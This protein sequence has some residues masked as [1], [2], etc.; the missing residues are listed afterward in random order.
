MDVLLTSVQSFNNAAL[1]EHKEWCY[2]QRAQQQQALQVIISG[3][4]EQV[5]GTLTG[6]ETITL[7]PILDDREKV[8]A[9][10]SLLQERT[11][12]RVQLEQDLSILKTHEASDNDQDK[13]HEILETKSIRL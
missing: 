6:I 11:T 4:D 2:I 8:E 10:R 1:R 13:Y 7:D 3:L 5:L 9:I 12:Q